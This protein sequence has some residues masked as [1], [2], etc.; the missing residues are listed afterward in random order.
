MAFTKEQNEAIE[1]KGE[2]VLVSAGAGSGKTTV[3]TKRVTA[4]IAKGVP[5]KK[6]LILTFTNNAA[7]SMRERIRKALEEGGKTDPLLLSQVSDVDAADIL[8]FDA[9]F[10]KLVRKY[11]YRLNIEENFTIVS[12][13]LLTRELLEEIDAAFE[14]RYESQDPA[15]VSLLEKYTL[16]DDSDLRKIVT[17]II[18]DSELAAAPLELLKERKAD[19]GDVQA[20]L[21]SAYAELVLDLKEYI[22]NFLTAFEGCPDDDEAFGE[23]KKQ[24]CA[25]FS[26]YEDCSS[27]G[28][29]KMLYDNYSMSRLSKKRKAVSDF[30]PIAKSARNAFKKE[31]TDMFSSIPSSSKALELILKQKPALDCLYDIAIEA[32]MAFSAFKRE[33]G[34][35]DFSDIAHYAMALLKDNEDVRLET[36]A[37]YQE[38]MVDEYQDNSS[39]QDE[40]LSLISSDNVFM[41]GDVKQSIYKFRGA[42]PRCFMNRYEDYKKHPERG[43]LI[44]MNQNFRSSSEVIRTVN[45]VF[46][47]LMTSDFG[48][49][50]YEKEHQIIA[51]NPAM[52][53]CRLSTEVIRY[54]D[55][56]MS[57]SSNTAFEAQIIADEILKMIQS[58]VSLYNDKEGKPVLVSYK[59]FALIADRGTEFDKIA[60]VF[61][62]KKIPLK[63]EKNLDVTE[64]TIIKVIISLFTVYGSVQK[65]DY[66]SDKFRHALLSLARGPIGKYSE[67][68]LNRLF[69]EKDFLSDP[70]V[71]TMQTLVKAGQKQD[72]VTIYDSMLKTFEVVPNLK[73]LYNPSS[74]LQFLLNYHTDI[75]GMAVLGYS[76]EDAIAYFSQVQKGDDE[77]LGI[78]LSINST[79]SN[80]VTLTNIHKSKGL[81]YPIVFLL[82]LNKRYTLDSGRS[83]FHFDAVNGLVLPFVRDEFKGE[84]EVG[85]YK[86]EVPSNPLK[87]AY[88]E[89][90]DRMEKEE[91]LR[92]LYVAMTRPQYQMIFLIKKANSKPRT[93]VMSC[94]SFSELLASAKMTEH[95]TDVKFSDY[96][97]DKLMPLGAFAQDPF[98][99]PYS[100]YTLPPLVY[101][102][103][104]IRASK[105]DTE[106]DY[107]ALRRGNELH[108]YLEAVDLKNHDTSFIKD[109]EAKA[110]VERFLASPLLKKY[111]GYED[112][113][114]YGY[115]DRK[116]KKEGSIDLLLV[117]KEDLAI[118]DYKTKSLSDEK[119]REQVLSYKENAEA[120]FHKKA[121]C[122]LYSILTSEVKEIC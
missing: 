70:L 102:E 58:R 116:T 50:D 19:D 75:E 44:L 84:H 48:G 41:V 121:R 3:L 26:S 80:A 85:L 22:R 122:Y 53:S 120:I 76:I 83:H 111:E 57:S 104:F 109:K 34:V 32:S 118:I 90:D 96:E 98:N 91:K 99:K 28:Q 71:Q 64:Q 13:S 100:Y 2:N 86:K 25:I 42:E 21:N 31:M 52:L 38:I 55:Q 115:I 18:K 54:E 4:L 89:K 29:L 117:G 95:T 45:N 94:S 30:E 79:F 88:E 51:A 60:E 40:F 9:F 108:A 69:L 12:A 27:F 103:K 49:A 7:S 114:E 74:S 39:F 1:T 87:V 110:L 15:F 63:I 105:I 65:G 36:K 47:K 107:R 37:S 72:I 59:D 14:K 112:Y 20:R 24:I 5:L 62:Q 61:A 67:E 16:K 97:N 113:H 66:V 46:C 82:G 68:K 11:F 101:A 106:A 73:D 8:T 77:G 10:Q 6:M 119:Y 17:E 93:S 33:H 81:E 43:H 56:V 78:Q 23:M 92:Q 35:Y